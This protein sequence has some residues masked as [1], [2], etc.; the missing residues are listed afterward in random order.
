MV[1]KG[2]F[3]EVVAA[4]SEGRLLDI[5]AAAMQRQSLAVSQAMCM[6]WPRQSLS[7][8]HSACTG[9]PSPSIVAFGTTLSSSRGVARDG[10]DGNERRLVS[11]LLDDEEVGLL[12]IGRERLGMLP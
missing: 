9:P 2:E 5:E 7:P 4:R 3:R 12:Q 10:T 8:Q 1:T 11:V 6:N